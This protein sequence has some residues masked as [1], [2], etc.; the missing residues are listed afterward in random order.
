MIISALVIL[1]NKIPEESIRF[2]IIANS[3]DEIDQKTK[4]QIINIISK[5]LTHKSNNIMEE[6]AYLKEQIPMIN[7]KIKEKIDEPYQIEYGENYFPEKEYK[8]EIYPEGKYE[9][10]VITLGEGK[11]DNF[12]CVLFPPLCMIDEEEDIEYNS[13][14]KDVWNRFF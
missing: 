9:S 10:L 7:E 6:R 12:W 8:G 2:R 5:E 3:N 11:G 4:K 13:V 14:I 1:Q